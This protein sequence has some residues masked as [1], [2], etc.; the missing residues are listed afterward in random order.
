MKIV[1]HVETDH[2]NPISSGF[3]RAEMWAKANAPEGWYITGH[4]IG[5]Y[6]DGYQKTLEIHAYEVCVDRSKSEE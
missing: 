5:T 2:R 4:Q 6:R 1:L 3:N